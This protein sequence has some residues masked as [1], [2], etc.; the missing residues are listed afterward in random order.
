LNGLEEEAEAHHLVV[1]DY[2][3]LEESDITV[4]NWGGFGTREGLLEA[5]APILKFHEG[6]KYFPVRVEVS[7]FN[8]ILR[9]EAPGAPH[10]TPGFP[11]HALTPEDLARYSWSFFN[12]DLPCDEDRPDECQAIYDAAVAAT[13]D[14]YVV[15]ATATRPSEGNEHY[16]IIQY[17]MNY[18]FNDMETQICGIQLPQRAAHE[19][20]WEHVSIALD[21]ALN[22][23]HVTFAGHGRETAKWSDVDRDGYHPIVY[24]GKG[25]HAHYKDPDNVD[26]I[27]ACVEEYHAGN[28]DTYYPPDIAGDHHYSI[29]ILPRWANLSGPDSKRWLEY[30]GYWGTGQRYENQLSQFPNIAE[31]FAKV[32]RGPAF[33]KEWSNP[34]GEEFKNL[35]IRGVTDHLI[36]D[37]AKRQ[38]RLDAVNP[39]DIIVRD[40]QGRTV[41]PDTSEI[42]MARYEVLSIDSS[43]VEV[44]RSVS[45]IIPYPVAGEYRV[46]VLPGR[47]GR[48]DD[49]YSLESTREW[50]GAPTDTIVVAAD[51]PIGDIPP[52]GYRLLPDV[53]QTGESALEPF[54]W[55]LDWEAGDATP[56]E[57]R[58]KSADDAFN[59]ADII[60]ESLRLNGQVPPI[61]PVTIADGTLT[62]QFPRGP[63]VHSIENPVQGSEQRVLLTGIFADSLMRL[64]APGRVRLIAAA[65]VT[66]DSDGGTFRIEFPLGN[67]VQEAVDVAVTL[68]SGGDL[69]VIV[70]DVTGR[71]VAELADGTF[72]PGLVKLHWDGRSSAGNKAAAG[73]Y[74]V[75]AAFE[76]RATTTRVILVR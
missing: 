69:I 1:A 57:W 6:E 73:L 39:I 66:Q 7:L 54:F 68:P 31:Q 15:Y 30:S 45:V 13:E 43:G 23:K 25:S 44:S 65:D 75:R 76:G 21:T 17:W 2:P 18:Y 71:L 41:S 70:H 26:C 53:P 12:L 62:V 34:V 52:E 40:P 14:P 8:S 28:G 33:R 55:I 36:C 50:F 46:D 19:G 48:M 60:P 24:V 9:A 35:T 58:L 20:D 72:E 74:F 37:T 63:A 27:E 16:V 56:V 32:W 64:E 10:D 29:E 67:I 42:P 5:F 22:P 3:L 47:G 11:Q 51:V 4:A 49:T 38:S 61:L 59:V